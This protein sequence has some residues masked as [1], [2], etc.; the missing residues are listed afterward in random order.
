MSWVKRIFVNIIRATKIHLLINKAHEID[1]IK[2]CND[3][4]INYGGIFYS[5]AVVDNL[6]LDKK[7]ITI[8]I[9]SHIRGELGVFKYGGN[10]KIGSRVYI[11]DHTRIRSGESIII[12]DNVLI[13]HGVNIADSSAHETDYLERAEAFAKLIKEGHP[14]E[15]GSVQTAAIIIEDYVWINF[16]AV[17][18]RGVRI[19]KG[20]I[21]AAGSVVTKDVPPFVLVAGAPA[22]IIKS[23][24]GEK[25]D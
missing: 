7:N 11:G 18:L 6:S 1:R 16:N 19:G 8:G 25:Y 3:Q 20:S 15:K 9:D 10:I 23:L 13:S 22:R 5:E 2:K 12:G 24:T 14:I 17:I 21:I 4:V